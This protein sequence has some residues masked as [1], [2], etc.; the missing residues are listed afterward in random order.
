MVNWFM[1]ASPK[2][3]LDGSKHAGLVVMSTVNNAPAGVG[4]DTGDGPVTVHMVQPRRVVFNHEN[5]R[6]LPEP[7]AADGFHNLAQ[8]KII[9]GNHGGRR[10]KALSCA[11][12]M[13]VGQQHDHEVI[14]RAGLGRAQF[15]DEFPRPIRPVLCPGNR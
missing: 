11:D 13:I 15:L 7:T 3:K 9:V 10:R 2:T 12:R 1:G 6:F 5:H 8:S 14:P 4:T